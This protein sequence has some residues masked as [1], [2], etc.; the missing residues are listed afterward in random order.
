MKLATTKDGVLRR[1][2]A[3]PKVAEALDI[4]ERTIIRMIQNKEI[5]AV[6][7][8]AN[9]LRIPEDELER[10]MQRQREGREFKPETVSQFIPTAE[11]EQAPKSRHKR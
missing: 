4:H 11:E 8:K 3:V 6:R 1:F 5:T 9:I 7:W 10:I 2:F